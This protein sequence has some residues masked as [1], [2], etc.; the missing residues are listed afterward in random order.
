MIYELRTTRVRSGGLPEFERKLESV[1]P[2]RQRHAKLAGCWHTEIGPLLQVVELWLFEDQ[3]HHAEATEAMSRAGGWPP[4]D[5][6][7]ARG[8][9]VE[10]LEATPFMRPLDGS[11]QEL[12]PFYELRT[13]QTKT[14]MVPRMIERWAP[15]IPAREELSPLVGAWHSDLGRW[16]HLWPYRDLAERSRVRAEAVERG[17]WPPD[18][19]ALLVTQENKIMLPTSFSPLQ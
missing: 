12:G 18:T 1:L 10:L 2:T 11:R 9:E 3:R 13:Y 6:E 15:M 8:V 5:G 16:F 14:G 19:S 17:V 7:L 4:A